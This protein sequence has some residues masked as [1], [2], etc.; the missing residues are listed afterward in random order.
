M[1][2]FKTILI[3]S[4]LLII[5][6]VKAGEW[7]FGVGINYVSGVSD[8][9][10]I[11]EDNLNT[12]PFVVDTEVILIPIGPSFISRYQA[13][14]GITVNIGLG[15]VFVII[16]D[17]SHTEVSFS[18]TVGYSFNKDGDTSPY[19]RAG[20]VVHSVSGDYVVSS[21][22]GSL[23]AIGVEFGRNQGLNWGIELSVD[24]S[25]VVLEDLTQ[26]GNVE[27]NSYDTQLTVF[28]LF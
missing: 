18:A 9:A 25:T 15:P 14:S 19:I 16:G 24:D 27:L 8:V 1:I 22:P 26:P 21:D 28:F 23:V 12:N 17:A 4:A 6:P 7:N 10:D 5:S 13:D 20:A 2:L 11:Y 3:G